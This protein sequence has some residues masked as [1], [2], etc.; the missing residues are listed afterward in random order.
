MRPSYGKEGGYGGGVGVLVSWRSPRVMYTGG[1]HDKRGKKTWVFV[2]QI[3]SCICT[4]AVMH[5][6]L[7]IFFIST[8]CEIGLDIIWRV[9][10]IDGPY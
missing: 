2:D 8:F 10:F 1:G 9:N 4:S 6:F 7:L 5:I 3:V